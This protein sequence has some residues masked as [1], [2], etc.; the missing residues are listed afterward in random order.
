[1]VDNLTINYIIEMYVIN[2]YSF[3]KIAHISQCPKQFCFELI[4]MYQGAGDYALKRIE[5]RNKTIY[6]PIIYHADK[7]LMV[8]VK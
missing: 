8:I 1:M 6:Q 5:M 2:Q 4:Q 3:D 7:N